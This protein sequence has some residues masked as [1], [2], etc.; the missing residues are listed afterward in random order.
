MNRR[1]LTILFSAFL[2]AI[3][4]AF[5]VYR[6]VGSRIAAV[7]TQSTTT[8]VAAAQDLQIGA[9]ISAPDLT[10]VQIVGAAPPGAILDAKKAIGRGIISSVYKGEPILDSRLAPEGS[11]GGLAATIKPGM[12]AIAVKVDQVV[13]VAG[14]VLPGMR[15]DVLVSGVPPGSAQG[16]GAQDTQIRTIL[17]NIEVLSAGTDI[18]KDAE[19]KPRQVQVVNLLVTP[20]QAQVIA[21]AGQESHVQLVLRNPLD[22]KIADIQNT[23]V[24]NLFADPDAPKDKPRVSGPPRKAAP[25]K[26]EAFSVT[27]YNGSKKTEEKFAVPEEKK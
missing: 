23:T 17:Q 22:T 14:F 2:V 27:V 11:G 12:R 5:I 15:V 8:I 26:P 13:G 7:K 19:G 1:L 3:L 6:L 18:A 9:V 16:G 24:G 20:D 4:S 10:T 21:L 25:R